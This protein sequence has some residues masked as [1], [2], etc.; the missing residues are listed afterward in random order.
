M[1]Q[2]P[3]KEK[4]VRRSRTTVALDSPIKDMAQE[5]TRL[6]KE[7]WVYNGIDFMTGEFVFLRAWLTEVANV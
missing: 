4:F 3:P 1:K 6:Q 5:L 7:G 2:N